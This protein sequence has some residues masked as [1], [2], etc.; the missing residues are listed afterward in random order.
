MSKL[1]LSRTPALDVPLRFFLTAPLFGIGAAGLLAWGGGTAIA[2]RWSP[3]VLAIT[4]LLTLGF[5]VMVMIGALF[6]VFPVVMGIG[7]PGGRRVA[8]FVH[9]ALSLGTA[10][11]AAGLIPV[12]WS[13]VMPM[14]LSLL[15][16]AFLLLLTSL[17]IGLV[18][19][20]GKPSI[21]LPVGSALI[22]LL[23]TVVLGLLL[24]AGYG[25]SAGL[26]LDRR[27]TDLHAVWG[28]LGWAGL[29]VVGLA[30]EV[31]PM[32]QA[33][34]AYP[35]WMRN[36]LS[37]ALLAAL[38]LWSLALVALRLGSGG[39][40]LIPLWAAGTALGLGLAVFAWTTLRL[41][42][43][44]KKPDSD[45]TLW[46]WRIG[47]LCLIAGIAGGTG[48]LAYDASPTWLIVA[49]A[50]VL[51][52]FAVSV[53]HGMLYKIVPFLVWLHLTMIVQAQGRNRR[54]VPPVKAILPKRP[55][56]VQFI[57]HVFA[58]ALLC[59]ALVHPN[60]VLTQAAALALGASFAFLGWTLLAG[61]WLYRAV[62]DGRIAGPGTENPSAGRLDQWERCH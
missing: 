19:A 59:A 29:L 6:Q 20:R 61:L 39:G 8:G 16:G 58:L 51:I 56:Q 50:L 57:L 7:I 28:L 12:S 45:L 41:Q 62:R 49:T 27:W 25:G 32:F 21:G 3:W 34:P 52:G 38:G 42:T 36:G 18:A 13:W 15:A 31:V 24:G 14:A 2:G 46:Y 26:A 11:L 30:Y 55:A 53:I 54:E 37:V 4:H 35:A 60:D 44:R 22:A 43:R 17:A 9:T 5:V 47:M 10:L 1:Q 23:V 33:T 40:W 48:T